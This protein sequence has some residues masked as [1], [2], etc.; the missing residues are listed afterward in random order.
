MLSIEYTDTDYLMRMR[1]LRWVLRTNNPFSGVW[2]DKNS[3][4]FI[5]IVDD[6]GSSFFSSITSG[7]TIIGMYTTL[8]YVIG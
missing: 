2:G 4:Y 3:F 7:M 5:A 8:I 6:S 1:D